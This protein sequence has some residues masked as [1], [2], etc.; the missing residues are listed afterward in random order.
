M[1][2]LT[3][4]PPSTIV[5][6]ILKNTQI[7]HLTFFTFWIRVGQHVAKLMETTTKGHSTI[8]LFCIYDKPVDNFLSAFLENWSEEICSVLGDQLFQETFH[9]LQCR[10]SHFPSQRPSFCIYG[11]VGA[12]ST[13]TAFQ[14]TCDGISS[15]PAV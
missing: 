2:L 1:F 3:P 4:D 11:R 6:G 13:D 5:P 12:D 7:H 8:P 10:V 15:F 14:S 9:H